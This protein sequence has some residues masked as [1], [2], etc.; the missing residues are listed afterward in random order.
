MICMPWAM[1]GYGVFFGDVTLHAEI[2]ILIF[3]FR[4]RPRLPA[5]LWAVARCG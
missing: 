2:I 5:H 1:R 3:V 4:Q